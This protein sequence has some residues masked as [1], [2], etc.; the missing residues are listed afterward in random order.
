MDPT[1]P[2]CVEVDGVEKLYEDFLSFLLEKEQIAV[3]RQMLNRPSRAGAML[4][5]NITQKA[6]GLPIQ[7][8]THSER[9]KLKFLL[10]FRC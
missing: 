4:L 2:K 8:V 1:V 7:I 6:L 5:L 3:V 10:T 9:V